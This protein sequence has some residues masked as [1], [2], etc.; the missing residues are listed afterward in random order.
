[1]FKGQT[2]G[3]I[4]I[5]CILKLKNNY[6]RRAMIFCKR[7]KGGLKRVC[8]PKKKF[9]FY[10]N[11]TDC[12]LIIKSFRR[13]AAQLSTICQFIFVQMR[14]CRFLQIEGDRYTDTYVEGYIQ[15]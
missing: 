5:T 8:S 1:M 6:P 4:H 15:A 3:C 11:D 7:F 14:N 13:D 9:S 12:P 2:R 10:F